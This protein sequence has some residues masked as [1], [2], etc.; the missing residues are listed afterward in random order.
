VAQITGDITDRLT[1][2][3]A[4]ADVDLVFHLAAK[5]HIND[6]SPE[7]RSEYERVN[8]EGT[9]RLV[10]AARAAGVKRLVLFST[11]NVYGPS[12]PGELHDEDSP[13]HPDSYY[14]ETKAQAER[15]VLADLPAVVLRLAAVYGPHMKG[16]YPRLLEALRRRRFAFVGDGLNRRTLVHV[17][18]VCRAALLA[19]EHPE[20]SGRTYNVTDGTVH[21]LRQIVE[22]ICAALNRRPPRFH[23]P[24]RPALW[25]AG[26]IER[27]GD[28]FLHKRIPARAAVAK[29]TEDIA[30]GGARIIRDLGFRPQ[31]ALLQSWQDIADS[32]AP[33]GRPNPSRGAPL[34]C[35][36]A[37]PQ[38]H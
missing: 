30:V 22:A 4:V 31:H 35:S 28:C 33:A 32:M 38:S 15:I 19:G 23:V 26:V 16:N 11:I 3:R 37:P 34:R 17:E 20:A 21:T 8:V 10:E 6:P 1:L 27:S 18:D 24:L 12:R 29:L 13:L 5:L 2:S 36:F 25:V 7:L 9:R 14:S